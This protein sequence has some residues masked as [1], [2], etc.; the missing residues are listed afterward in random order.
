[1]KSSITPNVR[2]KHL[3]ICDKCG[4]VVKSGT[5][6]AARLIA[7][8]HRESHVVVYNSMQRRKSKVV[9]KLKIAA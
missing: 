9:G 4:E 7:S 6:E 5:I 2:I 3:V 8:K 1:M